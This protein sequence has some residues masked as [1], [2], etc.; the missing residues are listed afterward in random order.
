MGEEDNLIAMYMNCA[1]GRTQKTAASKRYWNVVQQKN[2]CE[3]KSTCS[4]S[5]KFIKMNGKTS[6]SNPGMI[7]NTLL[8]RF[9]NKLLGSM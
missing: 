9:G 8:S 1:I 6:D 2:N 7:A 3:N 4:H 5:Y